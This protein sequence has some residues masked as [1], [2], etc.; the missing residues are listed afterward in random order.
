MAV[1]HGW[2]VALSLTVGHQG[3]LAA[4]GGGDSTKVPGIDPSH[5]EQ[6]CSEFSD[7]FYPPGTPP[8]RA[9]KN[10]IDPLSDTVLTTKR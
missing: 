10:E 4:L 3:V 1:L 9:I 6:I 7:V 2:I 8:E 5:W